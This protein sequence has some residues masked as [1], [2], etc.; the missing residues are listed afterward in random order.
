MSDKTE[1]P[2]RADDPPADAQLLASLKQ[3]LT[4]DDGVTS[5]GAPKKKMPETHGGYRW[6]QPTPVYCD[7]YSADTFGKG[8]IVRI[9]FGEYI[10]REYYPIYR[11]SV[12]MPIS[13]AKLLV[14]TLTRIIKE[15]ET[16]DTQ[17]APTPENK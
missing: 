2:K 4:R 5:E 17:D 9:A 11:V 7:H 10:G 6:L 15:A 8:T 14:Q 1:Q 3:L 16:K 12:A 13:D